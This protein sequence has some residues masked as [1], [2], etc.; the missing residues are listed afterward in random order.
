[1]FGTE[2]YNK[3]VR[4]DAS[5]SQSFSSPWRE[6]TNETGA[7]NEKRDFTI[8]F[9]PAGVACRCFP[10]HGA[11][12]PRFRRDPQALSQQTGTYPHV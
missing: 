5:F 3:P 11:D 6:A 1:M 2:C 8:T 7:A 4:N 9:P 12:Q 10:V